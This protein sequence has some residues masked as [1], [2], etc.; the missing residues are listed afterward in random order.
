MSHHLELRISQVEARDGS[1]LSLRHL[2]P[3]LSENHAT[4]LNESIQVGPGK[5]HADDAPHSQPL[6]EQ[7]GLVDDANRAGNVGQGILEGGQQF[8]GAIGVPGGGAHENLDSHSDKEEVLDSCPRLAK[9]LLGS[10]FT[11]PKRGQVWLNDF[12]N[13][14]NLL[15]VVA[16]RR[17]HEGHDA[18]AVAR[19]KILGFGHEQ[20]T[21]SDGNGCQ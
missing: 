4:K 13:P 15:Q 21:C 10:W 5:V 11:L 3:D 7:A 12:L 16:G 20:D 14:G 1:G 18:V 9:S 2:F 8:L 17:K 6:L 19:G